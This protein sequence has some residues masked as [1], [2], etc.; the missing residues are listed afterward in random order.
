MRDD[1][2]FRER[3]RKVLRASAIV[4]ASMLAMLA[5]ALALP[6]PSPRSDQATTLTFASIGGGD[7]FATAFPSKAAPDAIDQAARAQCAGRQWCEVF[8]WTDPT[9]VASAMPMTNRETAALAYQLI[10][11]RTTGRD[12]STFYCREWRA[13]PKDRCSASFTEADLEDS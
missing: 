13:V 6:S 2:A 11:N 5:L 7:L 12:R 10:I 9:K 8:G 1:A 4:I 3:N